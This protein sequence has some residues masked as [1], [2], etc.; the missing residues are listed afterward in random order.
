MESSGNF[1]HTWSFKGIGSQRLVHVVVGL[2]T[3]VK[4]DP[5]QVLLVL[6]AVALLL[7]HVIDMGCKLSL[8]IVFE[9]ALILL[10][11]LKIAIKVERTNHFNLSIENYCRDQGNALDVAKFFELF[12]HL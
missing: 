2:H 9:H 5:V 7:T 3:V 4:I 11:L 8:V 12:Q 6:V 1:P 10:L